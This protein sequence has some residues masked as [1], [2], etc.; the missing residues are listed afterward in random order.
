M[1]TEHF[2]VTS[3]D[4]AEASP[5]RFLERTRGHWAIEAASLRRRDVTFHDAYC[6]L[7]RGN[8]A[9]VMEILN[10][11]AC[12]IIHLADFKTPPRVVASLP[13]LFWLALSSLGAFNR[14]G[15]CCACLIQSIDCDCRA[16]YTA[17]TQE[18]RR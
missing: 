13:A 9:H 3:L 8:A 12:A 17:L 11:L 16:H 2:G 7:G 5:K 10:N 15:R 1:L 14:L 4:T 6:N 18:Q